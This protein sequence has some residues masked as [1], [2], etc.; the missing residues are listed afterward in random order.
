MIV[1][2]LENFYRTIAK[3]ENEKPR[4]WNRASS[5]GRCPRELGQQKLGIRGDPLTPRRMSIFDDGNFY[6]Q[7]LKDDLI[8]AM[9]G[10][11]VALPYGS[12]PSVWIEGVEIT[13][14]PD[15]LIMPKE[16]PT[17]GLGE[18]KSMSN[19]AFDRAVAGNIDE[20]YC[21]QAWTYA[22]QN[23]LNPIVFICVRKET[24][25]ICE[26]IFDKTATETIVTK[27][28]GGNELEIAANDPMLI[29]EVRSPFN[30]E[31]E[32]KVKATIRS[33]A[34]CKDV[35]SLPTGVR[36]VE[37]ETITAQGKAKTEEAK[38]IYGEPFKQ[39]GQWAYFA[40][41]R[42]ILGFPC[43]YCSFLKNCFPD[44]ALEVESGKPKWILPDEAERKRA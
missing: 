13:G 34:A 19:F 23:A 10:G 36:K 22:S 9:G 17:I 12:W 2:H 16:Y 15:F 44:A 29:A 27:R 1:E 24:R 35:S 37:P 40:T 8:K 11:I 5:I 18:I 32:A 41:G 7:K 21:C 20:T 6:D 28:Y 33:V 42:Q 31:I 26:V 43:S 4:R 38:R 39:N 30:E 3:A 25:H 14:T